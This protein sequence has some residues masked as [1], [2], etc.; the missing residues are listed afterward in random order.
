[1]LATRRTG[2]EGADTAPT[3]ASAG[4]TIFRGI[5]TDGTWLWY[6]RGGAAGATRRASG[7]L[8]G[9]E[10]ARLSVGEGESLSHRAA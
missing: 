9:L 1:M 6:S 7:L 8:N 3:T 5:E 2:A 10:P 4:S